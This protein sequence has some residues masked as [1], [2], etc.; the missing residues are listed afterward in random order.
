VCSTSGDGIDQI[1]QAI[2]QL[3]SDVQ[4]ESDS[5]RDAS[6]QHATR[7]ADIW[8]M[9]AALDPELARRVSRYTAPA[10]AADETDLT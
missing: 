5:S 1:I 6:A 8:R 9:V 4:A 2:D 7:I 10:R 3:A